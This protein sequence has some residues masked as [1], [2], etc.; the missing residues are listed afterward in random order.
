MLEQFVLEDLQDVF[1]ID[2]LESSHPISIPVGH[3]EEIAEIFDR[4]SYGKGKILQLELNNFIS[5]I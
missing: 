5:S 2:C 1:G 4:I 3:P